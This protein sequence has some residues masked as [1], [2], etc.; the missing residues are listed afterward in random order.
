MADHRK[1]TLNYQ[2]IV[3]GDMSQASIVSAV[4]SIAYLDNIGV[5]LS[6]TGTPTGT[7]AIQVSADYQQDQNKNVTNVGNWIPLILSPAP[8][9]SGAAG[10][11]YIDLNQ[12]SAPWI[13]VV[14]TKTSGTGTLQGFI[15]G[16]SV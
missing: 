15:N 1:L 6:W 13:R 4:S 11:A 14:Y 5:Q 7:F 9:A 16:K 2:N 10:T 3:N 8:A 12:L